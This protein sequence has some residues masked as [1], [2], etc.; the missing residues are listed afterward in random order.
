MS[1]QY[2]PKPDNFIDKSFPVFKIETK[3]IT[4]DK[5]V[6]EITSQVSS[7]KDKQSGEWLPSGFF[8]ISFFGGPEVMEL[9]NQVMPKSK[10]SVRGRISSKYYVNKE[11]KPV[12]SFYV[13]GTYL[14]PEEQ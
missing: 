12:Q 8:K 13:K 6:A 2:T 9:K 4:H 14:G 1:E 10:V 3:Q 7:G 5:Y 11:G